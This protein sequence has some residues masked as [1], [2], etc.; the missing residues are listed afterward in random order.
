MIYHLYHHLIYKYYSQESH[1]V[2]W[3]FISILEN[4]YFPAVNN[5][6]IFFSFLS[7]LCI[8]HS[9]FKFSI[10]FRKMYQIIY[11]FHIFSQRSFFWSLPA[12]CSTWDDCFLS[13][14]NTR[15]MLNLP[16]PFHYPGMSSISHFLDSLFAEEHYIQQLPVKGILLFFFLT[17][18]RTL[19]MRSTLLNL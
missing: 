10:F 3:S 9:F 16:A 14:C 6:L 4:F 13:L 2:H 12:F 1:L 7:A 8:Y 15:L 11:Q 17:V 18:V 19:N 5:Y